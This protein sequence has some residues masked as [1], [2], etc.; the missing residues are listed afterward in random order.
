M[1]SA[2]GVFS[3]EAGLGSMAILNGGVGEAA[4]G[5]QGQWAIFE[6]FFDTIISC[7][8]TALV[9]LCVMGEELGRFWGNGADLTGF[10][11]AEGLG[12]PGGYAVSVCVTLFAF[13][14]II[15]WYYMG[16]QS[17]G[18]SG[19]GVWDR[20][21]LSVSLFLPGGCVCGKLRAHGA[22]MGIVGHF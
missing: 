5:S 15:A 19:R 10:C 20:P 12:N 13:A 3:N 18:L 11:F 22:G 9:I 8:L 16:K 14:T 7:T 1:G 4:P 6:V 21:F 17:A 2:R